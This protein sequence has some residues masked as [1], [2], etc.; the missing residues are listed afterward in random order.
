MKNRKLL[1]IV[2]IVLAMTMSLGGT[3]AYLTDTDAAVNT[4]VVGNVKI[5]QH[6][7][8]RVVDEYGNPVKGV[9]GTDFTADYGI[10][11]SYKLQ[12]FTQNKPALPVVYVKDGAVV[13]GQ[14]WDEFQQLW[15]QV[16]APGS[17]ELFADEMENVID[18]F[19]FVENTGKSD[20]YYRTIIAIESPEGVREDLELIHLN[21]NTNSRFDYNADEEGVQDAANANAF[22][23]DING[24]RYEVY[25]AT[26]TE[27][28]KPGEVSRPSLLQLF[29]DPAADNEDVALFG[30][31]WDVLVVSQAVQAAGFADAQTALN[32]AFGVV[33]AESHPWMDG[34]EGDQEPDELPIPVVV[35]T[36]EELM[37]A[38]QDPTAS[39][40]L[41]AD[42]DMADVNWTAV[43]NFSG[44]FDGANRTIKNLTMTGETG[45]A[46]FGTLGTG[47]TIKNVRFENVAI[48]ATNGNAAV[49]T[50]DVGEASNVTFENIQVLSGKVSASNYASGMVGFCYL[51]DGIEFK[52]CVNHA[53]VEGKRANGIGSWIAG[54]TATNCANYGEI[55]G[56]ERAGG[57]FSNFAG[58]VSNCANYGDV[59]GNGN[60]PAAGIV[61]VLNGDTTIEYCTNAGDI[62]TTAD[63]ANASAAGILGHRPGSEKITIDYC[64]NTGNITAEKSVAGGIGT[65]LYG[66]MN[67]N[68]C[69]NSGDVNGAD[70]A[71]GIAPKPGFAANDNVKNCLVNG[72][73][74]S[75]KAHAVAP[76]STGSYYYDGNELKTAAGVA[77]TADEALAVLNGGADNSFFA[78]ADGCISASID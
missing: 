76:K 4:M 56:S 5:E 25:V 13:E 66:G 58:V 35:F 10:N 57:L 67:V 18:K 53:D 6:E 16:G 12:E 47:A 36:A 73:V 34:E 65:S 61:A 50:T 78:V 38:L 32:A 48:T 23:T 33:S 26:H 40:S 37:E 59:T 54:A 43:N 19:V 49:I 62:T 24:T 51:G 20:A 11:E 42:I 75:G 72:T 27:A 39:I 3:L 30:N 63:N 52:D 14:D 8:E 45:M 31:T 9:E 68:Y 22:Y 2:S 7:Y 29:L 77:V 41:A 71:G 1:L 55:T 46:M 64:V 69:Y 70:G 44:T 17:N 28:L 60:M 21:F 15:N 74:T